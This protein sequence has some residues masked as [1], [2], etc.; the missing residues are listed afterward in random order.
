[1]MHFP[2]SLFSIAVLA[3]VASVVQAQERFN[4]FQ[5]RERPMEEEEEDEETAVL[6]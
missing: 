4:E 3:F 1:M 2:R 5:V 6:S